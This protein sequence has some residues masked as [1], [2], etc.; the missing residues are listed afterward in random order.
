M[1]NTIYLD[2]D[3]DSKLAHKIMECVANYQKASQGIDPIEVRFVPK[4]LSCSNL[5]QFLVKDYSNLELYLEKSKKYDSMENAVKRMK[6]VWE[7]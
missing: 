6:E 7:K 3:K 4:E 1:K 2:L 5:L